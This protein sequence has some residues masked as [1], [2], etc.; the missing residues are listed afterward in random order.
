MGDSGSVPEK[1]KDEIILR[2]GFLKKEG[3]KG[4]CGKGS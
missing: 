3:A 4:R 1:G 2:D